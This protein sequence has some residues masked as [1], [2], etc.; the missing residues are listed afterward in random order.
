MR[1][2]WCTRILY[3]I[4]TIGPLPVLHNI[5]KCY[6]FDGH[7]IAGELMFCQMSKSAMPCVDHAKPFLIS[8]SQYKYEVRNKQDCHAK[9]QGREGNIL[10]VQYNAFLQDGT[11]FNTTEGYEPLHIVLGDGAVLPHWEEG[12]LGTCAGKQVVM[13]VTE[14]TQK[15][16]YIMAVDLIT[17]NHHYSILLHSQGKCPE[18]NK[19]EL[20]SLVT[21]NTTARMTNCTLFVFFT[22]EIIFCNLSALPQVSRKISQ[23]QCSYQDWG[24]GSPWCES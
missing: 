10:T 8:L 3:N 18:A 6:I 19:I 15:L 12:L 16:F 24:K 22:Q 13:V 9:Y 1:S 14:G 7:H 2:V 11:K 4:L 17:S 21:M 20:G 5:K 23:E